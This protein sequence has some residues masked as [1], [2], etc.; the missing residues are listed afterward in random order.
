MLAGDDTTEQVAGATTQPAMTPSWTSP[1]Q[2]RGEPAGIAS[3][4]YSLGRIL[5]YLLTW[6]QA[7]PMERL[8][9]LQY[10]EKLQREVPLQPSWGRGPAG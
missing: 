7:V 1:E 8:T 10:Y 9:P 2:L 4:I 6:E 5:Y 3:D